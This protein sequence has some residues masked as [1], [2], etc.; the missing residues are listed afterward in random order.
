VRNNTTC[1]YGILS[2]VFSLC[3]IYCVIISCAVEKGKIYEKDGKIYGRHKGLFKSK[4]YNYYLRGLSYCEGEFWEDA[5][6]DFIKATQKR[7]KDQR[8][9]RTYGVHFIN[10]FPN[11]ELGIA[12]FN[13][14]KY[15]KKIR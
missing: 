8:R 4:W 11:R 9:A 7:D 15:Q 6:A 3:L 10:Y 5:A 2:C 1:K 13:L 14:G 12:N